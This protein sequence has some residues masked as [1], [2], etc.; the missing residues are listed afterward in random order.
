MFPWG[1]HAGR[2][3]KH[4]I[5][6]YGQW[7]RVTRRHRIYAVVTLA[8]LVLIATYLGSGPNT[9]DSSPAG[10]APGSGGAPVSGSTASQEAD[11]PSPPTPQSANGASQTLQAQTGLSV[12]VAQ[13]AASQN[14]QDA[15]TAYHVLAQ[16]RWAKQEQQQYNSRVGADQ[17][18]NRPALVEQ[19]VV[20]PAAIARLCG[21]LSN[22]DIAGRIA[23]VEHAAAAAVPMAALRFAEEG[24]WGDSSALYTR[25]DDPL[26]QEWR[27][28][29]I[30]YL[31]LAAER[32]DVDSITSLQR[33]Y[34][35]GEGLIGRRDAALALQF[36]VAKS[37]VFRA[38]T[39]RP[40]I[41]TD[42][43]LVELSSELDP[44]VAA[45]ARNAGEE[46]AKIAL[47]GR[48]R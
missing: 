11:R 34:E 18:P 43:E 13:L 3:N 23:L 8:L 32:G 20:G 25:W 27:A 17:D 29:A 31:H 22:Q 9:A 41:A 37:I 7:E 35:T 33:Q 47:S 1:L 5:A 2:P 44:E 48:G 36:A 15:L 19:G 16:C 10:A 6:R 21:D 40:G 28:K 24:P 38:T 30:R 39:G 14:P 45:R 26:V 4:V 46:F 12:R 42:R